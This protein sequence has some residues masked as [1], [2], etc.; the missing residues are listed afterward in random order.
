MPDAEGGSLV[1]KP[2]LAAF[3]SGQIRATL[4][5]FKLLSVDF[6][7]HNFPVFT[8]L[9]GFIPSGNCDLFKCFQKFSKIF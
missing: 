5:H 7:H 8:Q 3:P 4:I 9:A 2:G 6:Y 1:K